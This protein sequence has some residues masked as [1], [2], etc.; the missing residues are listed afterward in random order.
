MCRSFVAV[1]A[2]MMMMTMMPERTKLRPWPLLIRVTDPIWTVDSSYPLQRTSSTQQLLRMCNGNSSLQPTQCVST[3]FTPQT[4]PVN[5]EHTAPLYSPWPVMED[6]LVEDWALLQC[7]ESSCVGFNFCSQPNR[8]VCMWSG[9]FFFFKG[10]KKKWCKR[11]LMDVAEYHE[12]DG[13]HSTKAWGRSKINT[14]F[15]L[16][17]RVLQHRE[18]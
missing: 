14:F 13:Q 7:F 5:S 12:K 3:P 2:R 1:V 16:R 10:V 6:R 4:A 15:F 18:F 11:S 17:S 9:F 8:M